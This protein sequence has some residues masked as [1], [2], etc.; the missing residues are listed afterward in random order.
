MKDAYENARDARNLTNP[1]PARTGG[2]TIENRNF[3]LDGIDRDVDNLMK[4]YYLITYEPP[5]GTLSSGDKE[6]FN[7]IKVNVRRRNMQVHTRDGFYT[8]LEQE[9]NADRPAAHPL[10]NAIFSPFLYSDINV[11]IAAGYVR[12][13]KAGYLVR[14]WIHLDPKDVTITETEDGGALIDLETACL[15]S[16][17]SGNV[18]DFVH[19]KYT[20]NVEPE[21][22]AENLA[23]IQKHGIRFAMLIPVKRPGSYYV[24]VAA[25]DTE[26]GKVGSA[27]QYMEIPDLDRKGLAL[28]SAFMITSDDDLN[29]LISDATEGVF[30]P[31]FQ[32]EEVLSPALGTYTLGNRLQTM[33]MV[34]NAGEKAIAGAEIEMKLILHKDGEEFVNSRPRPVSPLAAGN[35]DGIPIMLTL[36]GGTD[37]PP[38]DYLLQL[39]ITDKNNSK[40]QEGTASQT[41]SFTIM[42]R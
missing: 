42:E 37:L 21:K 5:P 3:F 28:S 2:I 8:S 22:K 29:W 9:K 10:Q 31:V 15:T 39:V 40:R 41:L 7:Q 33:A 16:D 24:R 34:Y 18:H 19:A 17:I 11:N 30:S 25:H 27:Y 4:G 14:S 1:L 26:S 32:A 35:L 13:A 12:D 20:F 38:G 23:W 6:I 36:T